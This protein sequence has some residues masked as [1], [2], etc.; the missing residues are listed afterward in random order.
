MDQNTFFTLFN[1]IIATLTIVV[2]YSVFK[3]KNVE[4]LTEAL[5]TRPVLAKVVAR[6]GSRSYIRSSI[7]FAI[8]IVVYGV[9]AIGGDIEVDMDLATLSLVILFFITLARVWKLH[10][11]LGSPANQ[12]AAY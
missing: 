9:T 1:S 7:Y 3:A 6:K 2:F 8:S 11:L 4:D 10:K 5:K 12:V